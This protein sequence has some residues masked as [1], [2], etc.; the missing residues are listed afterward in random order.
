MAGYNN[1]VF[2]S[3][4][5]REK[6]DRDRYFQLRSKLLSSKY[7]SVLTPSGKFRFHVETLESS[8]DVSLKVKYISAP[9]YIYC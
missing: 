1:P 8:I 9:D 5:L 2:R 3:Q 7:P 4:L 6:S